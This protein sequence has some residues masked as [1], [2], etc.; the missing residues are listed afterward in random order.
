MVGTPEYASP[1]QAEVM[2]GEVDERSDVYAL[3]VLMYELLIGTAP[4]DAARLRQA[5]LSEMLR[6]IRE[7]EAPPLSKRLTALGAAA[8]EIAARRQTDAAS[9]PRLVDGDLTWIAM[10]ALDKARERRY[11]SAADLAADIQRYLKHRP[12]TRVAAEPGVP[13]AQV[14]PPE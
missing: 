4:F 5:G 6:I 7:E 2:T 3:G 1:E 11:A 12:G 8:T 10:K 14:P 13:R 9:L